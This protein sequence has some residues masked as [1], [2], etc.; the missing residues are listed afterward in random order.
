[1]A[2]VNPLDNIS[3]TNK[4]FQ[5]IYP[6]LL[7]LV[8]KLTYKWDPSISNESD[9]GVILLKLNAIIADKNNYNIDKNILETFPLSVTQ[10]QNARQLFEQLGYNMRWYNAATTRLSFK[11]IGKTA[12][13]LVVN[14]PIYTAVCDDENNIVYTT[15]AQGVLP[16]DGSI[17]QVDAIQGILNTYSINGNDTITLDNID[18]NNRLYFT[19]YNIAENGI[20]IKN[21]NTD[22]Y[23]WEKV[24]NLA[25]QESGKYCYKF[26]VDAMN[27]RCYIEFPDDIASL[28]D[29]GLNIKYIQTQGA[30]GNV[31]ANYIVKFL[32]E[33]DELDSTKV[34]VYNVSSA[35]NGANPE[36]IDSAYKNYKKT[37]GT[38]NTLVTL[39][40]YMNAINTSGLVS[41]SFVC[42][43]TNDIQSS[44]KIIT[45][46]NDNVAYKLTQDPSLTELTPFDIKLYTLQKFYNPSTLSSYKKTFDM[47]YMSDPDM[48][49]VGKYIEDQKIISHNYKPIL[50]DKICYIRNKYAVN[51]KV[52]PQYQLTTIQQDEIISNVSKA[53]YLA[54]NAKEIDFG[55][56][57]DYSDIYNTIVN[58]D[59][60]IKFILLDDVVY[61]AYA[62]YFNDNIL[63]EALISDGDTADQTS[64]DFRKEIAAKCVLAGVTSLYI[65]DNIFNYSLVKK[66]DDRVDNIYALDSNLELQLQVDPSSEIQYTLRD[67]EGFRCERV[68]LLDKII[69]TEYMYYWSNVD[70]QSNVPYRLGSGQ[71]III[72]RKAND[73]DAFYT[74]YQY[75]PGT[76]LKTNFNLTKQNDSFENNPLSLPTISDKYLS[77]TI[78]VSDAQKKAC[79]NLGAVNSITVQEPNST[80]FCGNNTLYAYW[81]LNKFT[82]SSSDNS[83]GYELFKRGSNETQYILGSGEY[84]IYTDAEKNDLIILGQGTRITRDVNFNSNVDW[85]VKAIDISNIVEDGISAFSD[86][87]WFKLDK[88]SPTNVATDSYNM[89][90][91]EMEFNYI[92]A[93]TVLTFKNLGTSTSSVTFDSI[94]PISLSQV[95]IEASKNGQKIDIPR[96]SIS[97]E[98]GWQYSSILNVQVTQDQEQT[99]SSTTSSVSGATITSIQKIDAKYY[100]DLTNFTTGTKT[101]EDI[102]ILSSYPIIRAGATNMNVTT[103]KE[104]G[105]I[106][107]LSLMSSSDLQLPTG[108]QIDASTDDIVVTLGGENQSIALN[109]VV[110]DVGN[111]IMKLSVDSSQT[112][113]D[114]RISYGAAPIEIIGTNSINNSG[115][116]YAKIAGNQQPA[117]LTFSTVDASEQTV[118]VNIQKLYKYIRNDNLPE[119]V[120]NTI[121]NFDRYNIFDYTYDVPDA[122]DILNPLDPASFFDQRHIYNKFTIA[123]ISGIQTKIVNQ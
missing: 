99:L 2:I 36:S 66:F 55:Q 88:C 34:R 84:F 20:F 86:S 72:L 91:D 54:L 78:T 7:D 18:Y 96:D 100:E 105:E 73:S 17:I 58:A 122:V 39:R 3:Y 110:L 82:P 53:L 90:V 70:I 60:R 28:I 9:P 67:N 102:N 119:G 108:I 62:G 33:S 42:D 56:K 47:V 98:D 41:N 35:T 23:S 92:P 31:A 1:M 101:F 45:A 115:T 40:D 48:T 10:E 21:V 51:V 106:E 11:Y 71:N 112:G 13:S 64:I 30:D 29:R 49:D 68:S 109:N 15:V 37:V 43:R 61:T 44:Y 111:Y 19:G 107:Y 104:N 12:E 50:N 81:I 57:I 52:I 76:I 87:D 85:W 120:E 116:Y 117:T 97:S 38:F 94:T 25:I 123:E 75:G 83:N 59:D 8:K 118:K 113:F 16:V 26:G 114:F 79:S 93:G 4:D 32:Q 89:R 103:L 95:I 77:G 63:H 65:N 5:T 74:F 14:I 121:K 80:W 24:D 22:A 46:D 27:Q 69:Y 6:E